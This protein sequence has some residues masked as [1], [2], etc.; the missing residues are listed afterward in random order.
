MKANDSYSGNREPILFAAFDED[1][2][3][4][5]E[6]VL[7]GIEGKCRVYASSSFEKKDKRVLEKASACILFFG[8]NS[9]VPERAAAAAGAECGVIPVFLEDTGITDGM[10][11][12]LGS[13][14]AVFRSKYGSEEEFINAVGKSPVISSM[15][16][17][18][19][20]KNAAKRT[21]AILAVLLAL[22]AVLIA[23]FAILRYFSGKTIDPDST[24]G[25]LGISGSVGSV[26]TVYL[27]GDTLYEKLE[28][29]GAFITSGS[30]NDMHGRLYLPSSDEI[31]DKGTLGDISEFAELVN[32]EELALAGMCVEDIEP[33]TG[34]KK[35][36]I[37]DLSY[38]HSKPDADPDQY[39]L[40]LKGIKN[41]TSL[42]T[43][44]ITETSIKDGFD[45][46]G[47]LPS[48]KRLITDR[49]TLEDAGISTEGVKYEIVYVDTLVTDT[50]SF[51]RALGDPEVHL[52]RIASGSEIRVSAGETVLVRRGCHV[53]GDSFSFRND[54]TVRLYGSWETGMANENNYGT[55]IVENGGF[56]SGGMKDVHNYGSFVV[57]AGGIHE[58]ERGNLFIQ[59][60]GEYVLRG[61]LG[62]WIGGGFDHDGGTV[63]N[64]GVIRVSHDSEFLWY[65]RGS[66]EATLEFARSF[67]GNGRVEEVPVTSNAHIPE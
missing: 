30:T 60:E 24:L 65:R 56:L 51:R 13:N 12:L 32:L 61:T 50:D 15:S 39:A 25:K 17:T 14:Q 57:E 49:Y 47:E 27:Y 64:D 23:L 55:F 16:V 10:Q 36:R 33:L 4:D 41:M 37:L 54:G 63:R 2:R 7:E 59:A 43:L 35:L 44:Y 6:R 20:Q 28:E 58:L 34:L 45:E 1:D 5:A 67:P 42:E 40:S 52:I 53:S 62:I 29:R 11:L 18:K 21:S 19:K 31:T 22:A 46:L 48:F 8:K 26:R 66:F 38:Q 3:A 9:A